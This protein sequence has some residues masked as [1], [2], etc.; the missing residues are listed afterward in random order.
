M[1][2]VTQVYQQGAASTVQLHALG[3]G[4]GQTGAVQLNAIRQ[5][6]QRYWDPNNTTTQGQQN[7]LSYFRGVNLYSVQ[8]GAQN[9][10]VSIQGTTIPASGQTS[11]YIKGADNYYAPGANTAI[12]IG[13]S[14]GKSINIKNE[15]VINGGGGTGGNGGIYNSL[16]AQNGFAGASAIQVGGTVTI[17]NTGT[18][19]GGGGGGGGAGGTKSQGTTAG[20]AGGGGAS[21][22]YP[23]VPI[24]SSGNPQAGQAGNATQGGAGGHTGT[25]GGAG[26]GIN[27]PGGA[28]A[29]ILGQGGQGGAVGPAISGNQGTPNWSQ[30]GTHN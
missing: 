11:V 16:A 14:S 29:N 23:G 27:Q 9:Q 15:A 10:T 19:Y 7:R 5:T 6:Y 20:D 2:A 4:V 21:Y 28:G 18:I 24:G 30:Q 3:Q 26:G 8:G 22:G 25:Q 17:Y 12:S 1:V 13:Q